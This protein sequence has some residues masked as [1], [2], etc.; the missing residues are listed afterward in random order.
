MCLFSL[1]EVQR[2]IES[3]NIEREK[4]T[5]PNQPSIRSQKKSYYY[6]KQTN[7]K[8]EHN[9]AATIA[10]GRAVL[11]TAEFW[12]DKHTAVSHEMRIK[13]QTYSD[14]VYGAA[15][16]AGR[17]VVLLYNDHIS[18]GEHSI[19]DFFHT[20]KRCNVLVQFAYRF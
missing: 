11:P 5:L 9:S 14:R 19:L 7:K 2:D 8:R 20:L 17:N 16:S 10:T 6:N 4:E 12:I 18:N 3:K 15:A 1:V 13:L